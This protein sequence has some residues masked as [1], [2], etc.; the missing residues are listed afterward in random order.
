MIKLTLIDPTPDVAKSIPGRYLQLNIL[1]GTISKI[2]L[3]RL[4]IGT[5]FTMIAE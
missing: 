1:Y 4:Q 2:I 5:V 3:F